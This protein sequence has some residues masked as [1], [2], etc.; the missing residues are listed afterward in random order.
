[1]LNKNRQRISVY[2]GLAAGLAGLTIAPLSIPIGLSAIILGGVGSYRVSKQP[3]GIASEFGTGVKNYFS[4]FKDDA[5]D[6]YKN[7]KNGCNKVKLGCNKVKKMY[8]DFNTWY[9][10][11]VSKNIESNQHSNKVVSNVEVKPE[12]GSGSLDDLV[13]DI[14]NVISSTNKYNNS[15]EDV[16]SDTSKIS[17][18]IKEVEENSENIENAVVKY[19]KENYYSNVIN[20][21]APSKNEL[22]ETI[23]STVNNKNNIVEEPENRVL[24]SNHEGDNILEKYNQKN[25]IRT[26]N[27]VGKFEDN[28]NIQ[29]IRNNVY[30]IKKKA[31]V[32]KKESVNEIFP[33]IPSSGNPYPQDY[34][35]ARLQGRYNNPLYNHIKY[36]VF[37]NGEK[38]YINRKGLTEN[39]KKSIKIAEDLIYNYEADFKYG[40][41]YTVVYNLN[42]KN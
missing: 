32:P 42:K 33:N 17:G 15:R 12:A 2:S 5:V 40:E 13:Q 38:I 24:Y 8:T 28:G 7:T 23:K 14:S 18:L 30:N 9:N 1:M 37:E 27:H 41:T 20:L 10:N 6:L 31:D 3:E 11:K 26:K 34:V 22:T 35:F 19:E 39:N 29:Y 21:P 16:F 36:G 25:D 4:R